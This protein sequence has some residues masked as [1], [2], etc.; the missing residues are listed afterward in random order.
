[1]NK[2]DDFPFEATRRPNKL[3]LKIVVIVLVVCGVVNTYIM[4]ILWYKRGFHASYAVFGL[5]CLVVVAIGLWHW[6]TKIT[7]KHFDGPEYIEPELFVDGDG[8]I[9]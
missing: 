9:A 3:V 6:P 8:R 1:M 7:H 5:L 2:L 4:G